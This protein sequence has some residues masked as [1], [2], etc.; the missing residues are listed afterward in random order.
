MIYDACDEAK[1]TSQLRASRS[2]TDP[3]RHSHLA[4][5]Y[6]RFAQSVD[7]PRED[8]WPPLID[9]SLDIIWKGGSG[10]RTFVE[11]I[12][13]VRFEEQVLQTDHDGV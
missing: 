11:W 2:R 4:S 1:P 12:V 5:T 10:R 7:G 8:P 6:A 13:G 3:V 9:D